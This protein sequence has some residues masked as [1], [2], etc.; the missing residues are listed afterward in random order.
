[1]GLGRGA[2]PALPTHPPP[3]FPLAASVTLL[4]NLIMAAVDLAVLAFARR[5]KSVRAWR[6]GMARAGI[7]A[8]LLALALGEDRF[9]GFRLLAW[10]VFLHAVVLLAGSAV[11]WWP[12][13]KILAVGSAVTAALILLA[14]TD[15]FLIEPTW[16]EVSYR[17]LRSAKLRGRPT[18]PRV[19][20]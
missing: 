7:A 6:A 18:R 16:L 13:R 12:A 15:A 8:C 11:I 10:G 4:Y 14:A 2:H 19:R 17:R 9:G 1:M 3:V 20:A 5:R